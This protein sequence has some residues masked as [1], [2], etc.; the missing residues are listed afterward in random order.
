VGASG[1]GGE[2]REEVGQL[3]GRGKDARRRSSRAAL[4]EAG[5]GELVEREGGGARMK[6]PR[7]SDDFGCRTT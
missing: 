7:V 5:D 4:C 1:E 2:G 3:L 6:L